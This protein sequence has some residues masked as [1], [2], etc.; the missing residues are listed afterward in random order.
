MTERWRAVGRYALLS[1]LMFPFLAGGIDAVP[2]AA[3]AASTALL[4]DG[5]HTLG[6]RVD[7]FSDVI[8]QQLYHQNLYEA[9][10]RMSV[11]NGGLTGAPKH[12]HPRLYSLGVHAGREQLA[13]F[14]V[15]RAA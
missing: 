2:M 4:A 3:L 1:L 15:S 5:T 9:S 8:T 10:R 6:A 7:Y 11:I 14:A 13:D 12:L